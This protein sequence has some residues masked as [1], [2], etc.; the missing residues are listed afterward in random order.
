[1]KPMFTKIHNY[2]EKDFPEFL[3]NL[4]LIWGQISTFYIDIACFQAL[5]GTYLK[6][7]LKNFAAV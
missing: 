7:S 6:G 2:W 3:T 1:M 4:G 5:R